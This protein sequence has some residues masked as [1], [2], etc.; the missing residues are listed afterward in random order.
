MGGK[1][2]PERTFNGIGEGRGTTSTGVHYDTRIHPTDM[3]PQEIRRH[4]LERAEQELRA[5]QAKKESRRPKKQSRST[6]L[7]AGA[8]IVFAAV[9][10]FGGD[11]IWGAVTTP[12]PSVA[13]SPEYTVY[14]QTE[15]PTSLVAVALPTV[16]QTEQPPETTQ[17]PVPVE[18][19]SVGEITVEP[20]QLSA[21]TTVWVPANGSRYHTMDSCSG[22][23]EAREVSLSEAKEGGFTPCKRCKPPE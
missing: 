19:R 15:P 14:Q 21:K 2:K 6:L 4:A 7:T 23:K 8:V 3:S 17:K 13:P 5:E 1:T 10:L 9:A 12:A 16:M 22:M 18:A 11:T 20:I